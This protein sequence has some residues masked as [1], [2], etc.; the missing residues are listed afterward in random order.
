MPGNFGDMTTQMAL[1]V[2]EKYLEVG[3]ETAKR[4]AEIRERIDNAYPD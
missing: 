1:P 4:R 3:A 2:V